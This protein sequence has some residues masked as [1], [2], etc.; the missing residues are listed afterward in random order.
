MLGAADRP[1]Q[2]KRERLRAEAHAEHRLIGR[3]ERAQ[4]VELVPQPRRR[5]MDGTV[6]PEHRRPLDGLRLGP[7]IA[8]VN[9]DDVGLEPAL[10]G[11]L[12]QQSRVRIGLVF[13]DDETHLHE[14][15]HTC[16]CKKSCKRAV[17]R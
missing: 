9:S 2:R 6:R 14:S 16:L 5:G 1:A 10:A 7:R 3:V 11:P 15:L 13:D 8:R 12:P 4:P 17:F